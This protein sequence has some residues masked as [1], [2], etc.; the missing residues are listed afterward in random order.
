MEILE[1][2]PKGVCAS[3]MRV[4][5]EDGRIKDL[6]VCGGCSGNLQGIAALCKDQPVET[7]I[8]KLSGIRCGRKSTSC[9]DQLARALQA[10]SKDA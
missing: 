9:P 5:L 10:C 3:R 4:A 1:F 6:Q 8:E 7:V 2:T